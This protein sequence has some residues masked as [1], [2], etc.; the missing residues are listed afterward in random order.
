MNDYVKDYGTIKTHEMLVNVNFSVL[1][2]LKH[3][4][5]HYHEKNITIKINLGSI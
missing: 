5:K 2:Y 3:Y 4:Y 1:K